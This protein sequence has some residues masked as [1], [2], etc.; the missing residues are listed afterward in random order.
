LLLLNVGLVS[1]A[2]DGWISPQFLSPFIIAWPLAIAFIMWELRLPDDRAL[3]PASLW[4]IKNMPL[5]AFAS[6]YLFSGIVVSCD[7]PIK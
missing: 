4:K 3:L 7:D 2:S 6:L 1:G 5:M